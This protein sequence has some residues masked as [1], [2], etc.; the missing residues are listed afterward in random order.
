MRRGRVTAAGQP[1]AGVTKRD[2]AR[3]M[4]GRDLF[5][6]YEKAPLEPGEVLLAATDV[7]AQS[8]RGLPALR[9]VSL[10]VRPTRSSASRRWPATARPSSPR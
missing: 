6:L 10:E 9:G 4:V 2:L 3:L 7:E 1:A 8:D 5:G